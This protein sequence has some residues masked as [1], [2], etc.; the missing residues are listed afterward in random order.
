[1]SERPARG[2]HRQAVDRAEREQR[3]GPVLAPRGPQVTRSPAV[4]PQPRRWPYA[5]WT[6]ALVLLFCLHFP[7]LLADFPNHSPWMDYSKYTDEGWYGNAAIRYTLTG[8]WYLHGDFNPAVALPVWPLLLAGVFHFTGLSLA[9]DRGLAL[10]F[11]GLDLLLAYCVVRTQAARWVALLAVTLL[12][13]SPFLWAFSRLAI[14]EAPLICFL[15]LSWLLA[16][17]LPRSP[18]RFQTPMLAA[19]GLLLCAMILTKTTA[20]FLIPSALFLVARAWTRRRS[21]IRALSI[22]AASAAVPW[23]AW[24]FL[25]VRPH[26]RV[27]YH[28][29][30]EANR[31]PQP[32][33]FTGWLGAFWWALHGCLWISPALCVTAVAVLLLALRRPAG[34]ALVITAS[35]HRPLRP[36]LY[37]NPLTAASLLALAGYLFFIGWHNSPQ[38]RYYEVAIDPLC[39]M[40]SLALADLLSPRR[41]AWLRICGAAAL[42]TAIVVSAAG[43][44]RIAAFLRHPE[45]TFLNT[46]RGVARY[47]DEH[48]G[49]HRLLLSVSGDDIALITGLP[50]ICDDYGAWDLPYR[51]HQYQ[52][53]W[54]AAWNDLDPGTLADIQML[55][56]L[57]P[58]ASFQAFDD[59]DRNVLVLYQLK[60]LPPAQQ[61]YFVDGEIRDNAGR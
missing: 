50:A 5:L 13:A 31:W 27:D 40:L 41:A 30:F 46:A 52:P 18:V 7:H 20:I 48:P 15:L 58:V 9:A 23:C 8:H 6:L 45:Y 21:G 49:P 12:A 55:D 22:C 47:I 32:T 4:D 39:F 2:N 34:P 51:M 60:P 43:I 16:L 61:T 25:A 42:A 3:P 17:L 26:Y 33:T 19:I 57:Q 14:L 53:G 54:Y 59:P 56:A 37:G 1:M 38:P 36:G 11:F 28:Y 10:I 24:Y 35:E 44:F 29:L